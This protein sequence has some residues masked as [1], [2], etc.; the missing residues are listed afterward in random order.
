MYDEGEG[1]ASDISEDVPFDKKAKCL[2]IFHVR[3]I[4]KNS[5]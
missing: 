1:I 2:D 4:K 3:R 5:S